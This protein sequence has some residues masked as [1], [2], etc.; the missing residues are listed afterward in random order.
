[1]VEETLIIT[2]ILVLRQSIRNFHANHYAGQRK[3]V[4]VTLVEQF[5]TIAKA[6]VRNDTGEG[7]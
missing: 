5:Q 6:T 1:M 7:E 3:H 2:E 4:R